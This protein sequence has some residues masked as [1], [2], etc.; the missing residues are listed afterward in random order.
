[1]LP[2]EQNKLIQGTHTCCTETV[3]HLSSCLPYWNYNVTSTTMLWISRCIV[4][5]IPSP[6]SELS[7]SEIESISKHGVLWKCMLLLPRE[8]C[9]YSRSLS[10]NKHLTL[11][12][13]R[14]A[15]D[16]MQEKLRCAINV[17]WI[18][19]SGKHFQA[20]KHNECPVKFTPIINL[21]KVRML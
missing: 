6:G 9:W 21:S 18:R 4:A 20:S 2:S 8:H 10:C 16:W 1:M 14:S 5:H 3:V 19:Q 13:S 15:R 12:L 17:V 7:F 11:L